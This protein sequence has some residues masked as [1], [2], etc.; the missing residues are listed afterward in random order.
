M[1]LTVWELA[2][3]F[4]IASTLILL[5]KFIRVKVTIFQK[6]YMPVAMM[7][8]LLAL[9]LG[10]NGFDVLPLSDTSYGGVLIAIIFAS[11][12]LTTSFPKK[13]DLVHRTGKLLAFNQIITIS[14]WLF[15]IVIGGYLLQTFWPELPQAFGLVMPSGFMGGHGTAVAVGDTLE[16]L[17]WD[18]ATSLALTAATFG[19]F[20]AVLG[21]LVIVNIISRLGI[22]THI[23]RFDE[24]DVHFRKGVIPN[25]QR[26]SIGAET[27]SSSS[28]NAFTLH[29]ALVGAVVGTAYW[30]SNFASSFNE[31]VSVPTFACAFVFG[32]LLRV[33]LKTTHSLHHFDNKLLNMTAGSATDYLVFFGIASIKLSVLISFAAPFMILMLL[34]IVLCLFL[35]FV[36]APKLFGKQWVETGLFSWGWMT[37]TVAMGILL[38]KIVDPKG[39]S[40]VLDDY[41]IAYL[42]GSIIDIL[43][44]ALIPSL[45]MTGN[46][47]VV[48][49]ILSS[50]LLF[51]LF[52]ATK[53]A[54]K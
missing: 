33:F 44:V 10:H 5:C 22:V 48:I 16:K 38:L 12:G 15:A 49:A 37:G 9:T 8:G 28:V 51:V 46:I 4:A 24:L 36:L 35:T 2:T 19:V 11:L 21:G 14:Q 13:D 52:A 25:E 54:K 27:V 18:D 20:L 7:A 17:S 42:P 6:L 39:K 43:I 41:A 47:N 31:F 50:Y 34:G 23:R 3:D 29:I 1:S 30:F 32:C 40:T 45:I 26:E 53:L